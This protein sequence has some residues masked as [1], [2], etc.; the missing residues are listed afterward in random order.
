[1][2][3]EVIVPLDLGRVRIPNGQRFVANIRPHLR[4]EKEVDSIPNI[5]Q[6]KAV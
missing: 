3:S 2:S 6:I 5:P 4:Q 1:M